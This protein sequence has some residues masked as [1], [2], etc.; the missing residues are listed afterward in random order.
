[1][2][3]KVRVS[4]G[5]DHGGLLLKSVV[6]ATLSELGYEVDDVGTHGPDSVDYPEF[7]HAVAA[8]VAGGESGLGVLICGTGIGMSITANK[9]PGVRAALCSDTFSAR[10]TRSHNDANILCLGERVVGPGLAKD[11]V[12][13]FFGTE[14]EG[15]RHARRV[16]K[17][18]P[19][20]DSE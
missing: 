11:I 12:R 15:G 6:S 16:S 17:I 10:M 9:R 7:A 8:K 5:A 3:D 13:A 1:M 18:E 20:P 2:T 4:V 14:F 19:V